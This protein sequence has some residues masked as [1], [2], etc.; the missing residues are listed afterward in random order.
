MENTTKDRYFLEALVQ[1]EIEA[2]L[3]DRPTIAKLIRHAENS[4]ELINPNVLQ[5]VKEL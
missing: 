5:D 2:T 3:A 4:I 1:L